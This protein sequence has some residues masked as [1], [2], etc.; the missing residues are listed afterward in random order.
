M[1]H[2]QDEQG[3]ESCQ[4]C[5]IGQFTDMEGSKAC[6]PCGIGHF[7][8]ETGSCQNVSIFGDQLTDF[9]QL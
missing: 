4:E 6:S 2:L 7:A 1:N 5:P 9:K 3:Q 8:D